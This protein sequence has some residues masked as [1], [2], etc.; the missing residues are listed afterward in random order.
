MDES[1]RDYVASGGGSPIG[2]LRDADKEYTRRTPDGRYLQIATRAMPDGSF[3]RTYTDVTVQMEATLQA[4]QAKGQFLANMSHEL[5]TPLS[6]MIGLMQLLRETPLQPAQH[7]YLDKIERSGDALLGLIND[8]L[9]LSK[10]ESGK[11]ELLPEPFSLETVLQDLGVIAAGYQGNKRL[12]LCYRV[13][14]EVRDRLVGDSMRLRQVLINLMGNAIKFTA[15]GHVTLSVDAL[16][17][18]DGQQRLRFAVTD[19]GI[20]LSA[21]QQQR[22]FESFSQAE[23]STARRYGGSGLGLTISQSIVELMGGRLQVQSQPGQDSCFFFEVDM[24]ATDAPQDATGPTA[25]SAAVGTAAPSVQ[26]ARVLIADSDAQRAAR[27]LALVQATGVGSARHA[28][29]ASLALAAGAAASGSVPAELLIV[30]EDELPAIQS[31]AADTPRIVLG[32]LLR[33]ADLSP[34]ATQRVV[35]L[36]KPITAAQMRSAMLGLLQQTTAPATDPMLMT[37]AGKTPRNRLFGVRVLVAEDHPINR[38]VAMKVLVR[39][40]ARVT[41]AEN[42]RQA[43]G[44]LAMGPGDFDLVLMDMQMPEMDGLQA[45]RTIRSK[46]RLR[47][48]PVIAMT[49]NVLSAER[50]A[51]LEASMNAHLGKPLRIQ[52]LIDEMQRVAPALLARSRD[53]LA[54]AR[55]PLQGQ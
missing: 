22:I 17:T 32:S 12:D 45:T 43:V 9:D 34:S 4:Q 27:L 36:V 31:A 55:P 48:L 19:T 2:L 49:A 53:E 1:G 6:A 52:S 35:R 5:R 44:T 33:P 29:P 8:V 16:A 47:D 25:A 26:G 46:L 28:E 54:R 37:L 10:I 3:V 18:H 23:A 41:V 14:T 51:C 13:G 38:E 50:D 40:G 7:D 30:H 20:G 39:E 11:M 24:A 42:G 21:E 15:H